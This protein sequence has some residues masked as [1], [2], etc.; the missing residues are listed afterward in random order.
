MPGIE[1]PAALFTY[2]LLEN[3][4]D[5]KTQELFLA[6]DAADSSIACVTGLNIHASAPPER[7]NRLLPALFLST[8][9]S[10]EDTT[11]VPV[12]HNYQLQE[13]IATLRVPNA[14][15]PAGGLVWIDL[16]WGSK[17]C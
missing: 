10:S 8:S 4:K 17:T 5:Y 2:W 15:L 6:E 13:K 12:F 3:S 1:H 14:L 7:T 16:H 9:G 11:P